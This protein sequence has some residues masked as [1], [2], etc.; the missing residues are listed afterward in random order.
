LRLLLSDVLTAA[1]GT[2]ALIQ[3]LQYSIDLYGMLKGGNSW[4]ANGGHGNGRKLPI[5]FGATLLNFPDFASIV[6]E[7]VENLLTFAED[8]EIYLSPKTGKVI[9][10]TPGCSE[11]MYW[12]TVMTGDGQKDCRDPYQY[13]DGTGKSGTMYQF[14]CTSMVWKDA[15]VSLFIMPEFAKLWGNDL[16]LTYVNRW[17]SY[18]VI[19]LPDPCAPFDG[20]KTNYGVTF[21]PDGKGGCITGSGRFPEMNGTEANQGYYFSTFAD[22][23]Y[24]HFIFS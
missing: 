14:C 10:G 21:G 18:G 1:N 9:F 23:M 19:S 13:I 3:Y 15:A 24:P 20:N 22:Q 11:Q 12:T 4:P 5:V 17:V 7:K 6:S 16:M 2:C 8:S